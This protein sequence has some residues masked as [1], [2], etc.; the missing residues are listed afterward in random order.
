MKRHHTAFLTLALVIVVVAFSCNK[1]K[2]NNGIAPGFKSETGTGGN[3]NAGNPTVTGATTNTNLA[4]QNSNLQVGGS[5]WTN[6][7]CGSTNSLT[8]K[9]INGNVI[10]TVG[11]AAVPPIGTSTYNIGASASSGICSM[12]VNEAPNQPSGIVWYGRSGTVVVNTSTAAITASV[13]N[14]QCVQ[15]NFNYPIVSV[16]GNLGC[17][18]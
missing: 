11:F 12:M 7:T 14:A 6:P 4:T 17:S 1:K 3:P 5:G 8:L 2:T 16:S 10:V 18:Q 9:A 15:Q 13:S